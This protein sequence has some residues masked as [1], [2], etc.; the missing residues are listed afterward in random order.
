ME[1]SQLTFALILQML[2][3][4]SISTAWLFFSGQR[5]KRRNDSLKEICEKCTNIAEKSQLKILELN[6]QIEELLDRPPEPTPNNAK[7]EFDYGRHLEASILVT[8]ERIKSLGGEIGQYKQNADPDLNTAIIRDWYLKAELE[9]FYN[10]EEITEFWQTLTTHLEVIRNLA[11]SSKS[12]SIAEDNKSNSLEDVEKELTEKLQIIEAITQ[13]WVTESDSVQSAYEALIQ[14]FNELEQ[15]HQLIA[16]AEKVKS[17]S[18]NLVQHIPGIPPDSTVPADLAKTH[19]EN[20]EQISQAGSGSDPIADML[21]TQDPEEAEEVQSSYIELDDLNGQNPEQDIQLDPIVGDEENL[22]P[23]DEI[24]Q[25]I[26]T[27]E[28][29]S[30]LP[31]EQETIKADTNQP[32]PAPQEEEPEELDKEAQDLLDELFKDD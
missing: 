22:N 8:E 11:Q 23:I 16:Q 30:N 20:E 7:H 31:P 4:F 19:N 2:I 32:E 18:V 13:T 3:I 15:P 27:G 6:T 24:K 26:N 21:V 28:G 12:V 17:F 1:V 14:A 25:L 5:L 10:K 29:E 9:G